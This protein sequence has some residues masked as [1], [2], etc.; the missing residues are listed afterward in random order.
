MRE[1][2]NNQMRRLTEI[3]QIRFQRR[4]QV[5]TEAEARVTMQAEQKNALVEEGESL[6]QELFGYK[7]SR[8]GR[9]SERAATELY[10]QHLKQVQLGHVDRLR[11]AEEMLTHFTNELLEAKTATLVALRR[12]KKFEKIVESF[13][14]SDGESE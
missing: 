6:K 3:G 5:Q 12:V 1:Q 14:E 9:A 10:I 11:D 7:I 4:L 8:F 13:P 2:I